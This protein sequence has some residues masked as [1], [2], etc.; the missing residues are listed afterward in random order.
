MGYAKLFLPTTH[1]MSN[2]PTNKLDSES[3]ER[4]TFNFL[5]SVFLPLVLFRVLNKLVLQL[6]KE[7][8]LHLFLLHAA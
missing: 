4:I 3:E 1:N 8:K 6:K 5:H 2:T 7:N